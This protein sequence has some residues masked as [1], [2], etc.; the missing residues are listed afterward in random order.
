MNN[1]LYLVLTI[2]FFIN[3]YTKGRL[4]KNTK[5]S[6]ISHG[7]FYL[8]SQQL[9]QYTSYSFLPLFASHSFI[10]EL[11]NLVG[12]V[13]FSYFCF[14]FVPA[15]CLCCGLSGLPSYLS[16]SI[17]CIWILETKLASSN[18]YQRNLAIQHKISNKIKSGS[19]EESEV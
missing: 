6:L 10:E 13:L 11:Q 15:S 7:H 5:F 14:A 8:G 1:L 17:C 2:L 18:L 9:F 19:K 12:F 3:K 16:V 4:I